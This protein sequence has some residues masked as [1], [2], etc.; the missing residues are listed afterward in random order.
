[1][2]NKLCKRDKVL[3]T[4]PLRKALNFKEASSIENYR[5]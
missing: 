4:S 3:R 2:P 5:L 1:M